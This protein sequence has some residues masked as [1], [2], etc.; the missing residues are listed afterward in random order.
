MITK[1][2][3][4]FGLRAIERQINLSMTEDQFQESFKEGILRMDRFDW[5][6]NKI[7]TEIK[8][9]KIKIPSLE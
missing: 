6:Y 4:L 1:D 8:V 7:R 5:D 9:S 2:E 3:F